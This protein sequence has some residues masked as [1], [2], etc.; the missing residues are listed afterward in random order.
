M[1]LVTVRCVVV[2]APFVAMGAHGM[3]RSASLGTATVRGAAL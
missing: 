3:P 2:A 1:K